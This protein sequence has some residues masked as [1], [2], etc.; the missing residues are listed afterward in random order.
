MRLLIVSI[1]FSFVIAG[2]TAMATDPSLEE[3]TAELKKQTELLTQQLATLKAQVDLNKAQAQLPFA[4]LQGIKEGISSLT[5]PSGK[6]GTVKVGAGTAG[7]ALLR[8]KRP[9]IELLEKVADDLISICPRGAVILTEAQLAQAYTAKFT[10]KRIDDQNQNLANAAT[11]A[12]PQPKAPEAALL[13]AFA[14][15]A[16]TLGF[17][18]ETMNSLFKLLR[19]NRSLDVFS[20]DA[21]ALAMLGY[22][23]ESKGNGFVANPVMLGDKVIAEA[24]SLLKKL[25]ELAINVQKGNDTLAQVKK[26]SDDTSKTQVTLPNDAKISLLKA[27]IDGATSLFDSLNPSKKP[28]VFWAQ[29]N[30]QL[31]SAR[32][33][34]KQ[35]LIIEA[36]A[37]TI[38]ITE[39]RWYASDRILATGEVLVMYRLFTT[40]GSLEKSGIIQKASSTDKATIDDLKEL[41]LSWPNRTEGGR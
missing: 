31:I 3:K 11:Q 1:F 9:M 6:E 10:L 27:E 37:Q 23:L 35:R 19:T 24:D 30:G 39:S 25:K 41:D 17:T 14:A 7:T 16:Y 38:Q 12:K 8:S 15:G 32:I 5:L 2:G 33:E 13:P 29:V 36:K 4:E 20:A 28:E 34:N 26:Y 22:L 18:L 40:N 21:E